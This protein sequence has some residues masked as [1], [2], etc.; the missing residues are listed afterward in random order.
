[1][2]SHH[3]QVKV[4]KRKYNLQCLN[5]KLIAEDILRYFS[6]KSAFDDKLK[7]SCPADVGS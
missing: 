3:A 4:P 6:N 1:M 2:L 5:L 7:D